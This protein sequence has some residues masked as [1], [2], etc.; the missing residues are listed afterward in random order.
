MRK[1]FKVVLSLFLTILCISNIYECIYANVNTEYS[2]NI[3]P[4]RN[5]IYVYKYRT[6]NGIRCRRLWNETKEEWAEPYWTPCD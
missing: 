1:K 5:D 3:S 4:A 6:I 2:Y